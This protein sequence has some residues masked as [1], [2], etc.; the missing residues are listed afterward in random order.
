MEPLRVGL[1]GCS[2][3]ALRAH[4]PAL[5]ALEQGGCRGFAVRI[6]AVCSRTR[7]SMAKAEAKIGRSVVRH[8]QMQVIFD[9]PKIDVVR[10]TRPVLVPLVMTVQST[11]TLVLMHSPRKTRT[12]VRKSSPSRRRAYVVTSTRLLF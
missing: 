4:I 1:V 7:K 10:G 9:D 6:E 8:A 2:W 3:F 11:E 12:V 5:L